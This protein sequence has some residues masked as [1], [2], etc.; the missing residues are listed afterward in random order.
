MGWKDRIAE[1]SL[2][3]QKFCLNITCIIGGLKVKEFSEI[4][5]INKQVKPFCIR[6]LNLIHHY[7]K[8][9]PRKNY[10]SKHFF[11][12]HVEKCTSTCF[13]FCQRNWF[14][15][16]ELHNLVEMALK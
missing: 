11:C 10:N 8:T 14:G 16:I 6:H 5:N 15:M 7:G 9:C 2:W 3:C 13:V 12:I 1:V 4:L